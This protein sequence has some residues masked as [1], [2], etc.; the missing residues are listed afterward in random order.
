MRVRRWVP[1]ESVPSGWVFPFYRRYVSEKLQAGEFLMK[2]GR[3]RF[4]TFDFLILRLET[5]NC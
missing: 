1:F 2:W 5:P 4:H 3:I